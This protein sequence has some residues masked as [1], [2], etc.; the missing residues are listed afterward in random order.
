[1]QP[2][3]L[4]LWKSILLQNIGYL[5]LN[6]F[7]YSFEQL[8]SILFF[9]FILNSYLL[10]LPITKIDVAY[11]KIQV[12]ALFKAIASLLRQFDHVYYVRSSLQC[13]IVILEPEFKYI[14]LPIV[15]HVKR[16]IS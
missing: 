4:F 8:E 14:N 12:N 5:N 9:L 16:N 7:F 3:K 10:K 1:M 2:Q 13:N 11:N 15:K 6:N